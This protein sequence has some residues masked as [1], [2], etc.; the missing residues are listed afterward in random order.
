[1]KQTK[2]KK[3]PLFDLKLSSKAKKEVAAVL[4]EGWLT[5]GP[6]VKAFEKAVTKLLG[7]KYATAVSSCTA[8]LHLALKAV[9]AGSGREIITTPFTFAATIE[10]IIQAGAQPVFADI[11]PQT[12]NIDPDEVARKITD[13]TLAI[14]PVDIAGHP[15]DYISLNQI[16]DA[17]SLV[18]LA[19]AAHSIGALCGKRSIP[20]MCDGA[21]FS[22]YSTKNLTC[23]EGGMVV[24]RHKVMT[25][26][27]RLLARHGLTSGTYS[28]K[29]SGKWEY[30]AIA[31]GYK[32]NMSDLHA[33]VGLGQLASFEK[34][35]AARIKIAERYCKNLS[36]LEDFIEIPKIAKGYSH[37]W[38]LYIIKLHLSHLRIDRNGFIAAMSRQ[39]IECGVHYKP[40]FELSYYRDR[41]GLLPQYFPNAAY[42]GQCVV[43]L[44]LYPGMKMADV[45]IVCEVVEKLVRRYTR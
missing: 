33:A 1:M 16:C 30:D 31:A 41:Y 8:G 15:A 20:K 17:R 36:P 7:V 42:A 26:R 32:A 9:G 45:D 4:N 6:R 19:D 21:V 24:S 2:R 11:N 38:H 35:Q 10:A 43:S 22:F 3:I 44:P 14:V 18:L 25:D 39:G 28:R 40:I 34:D 37:G 27:V 29:S 5:S 13:N 12:L 23:G